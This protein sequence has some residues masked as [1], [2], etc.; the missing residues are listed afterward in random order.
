[1]KKLYQKLR[2]AFAK[3]PTKKEKENPLRSGQIVFANSNLWN[4]LQTLT[5]DY[6]DAPFFEKYQ[7]QGLDLDC[8]V[9]DAYEVFVEKGDFSPSNRKCIK[10]I[11]KAVQREIEAISDSDLNASI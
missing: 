2:G 5:L 1:M 3:S 6:L 9:M 4:R 7:G 8:I 10:E 11:K